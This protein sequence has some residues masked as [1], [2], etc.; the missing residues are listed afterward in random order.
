M[1][2]EGLAVNS[3]AFLSLN[4]LGVSPQPPTESKGPKDTTKAALK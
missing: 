2:H 1:K 3:R 4:V